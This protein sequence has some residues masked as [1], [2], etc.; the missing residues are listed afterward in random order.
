MYSIALQ[1]NQY[2]TYILSDRASGA[3]M[4]VVPERGGIITQWDIQGTS[5]LYLDAERFTD[6][7][8]SVRG[9]IPILF[10]ICGN[11]PDDSYQINGQTYRLKQH[12]FVRGMPWKVSDRGVESDA[13]MLQLTLES[14]EDTLLSY[15]FDFQL[16]FTYRLKGNSIILEQRFTNRSDQPMPFSTG[17]HPYFQVGSTVEAKSQLQLKIP[18][19]Q[20][21][22]NVTKSDRTYNHDFDWSAP[23]IDAAF[24]PVSAQ[25]AVVVDPERQVTL[26]VSYDE[27]Y[28]AL[29][30]WTV[31][32]KE[33]YCIEPWSAPRN[34]LNTGVDLI[35][36][37][38]GASETLTTTYT[39]QINS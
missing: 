6:P 38:P 36:L 20:Y 32:G 14:N 39:A 7:T 10:P 22:D 8:L 28:R 25:Q 31:E 34:A 26:T 13:A 12:G 23:E 24:Y 35:T 19:T 3:R 30:F 11:L 33:F 9:G 5:M 17:Q 21:N 27:P 1:Q 15:P 18:A 2:D 16:Q 4:E 29:V 37:A